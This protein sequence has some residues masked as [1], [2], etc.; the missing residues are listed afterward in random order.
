MR[1]VGQ[2]I[3]FRGLPGCAA[4]VLL[5]A[6]AAFA[7]TPAQTPPAQH[8][9]VIVTGTYDPIPLQ[10]SDRDVQVENLTPQ[11]ALLS[12]ALVDF[13][14][15]DSTIDLQERGPNGIQTDISIRGTNFGQTL[16]LLNGLRISDVQ[17]GHYSMDLPIPVSAVDRIEV[18]KGA[19]STMY[20]ADA[21]G[22]V[23]NV[24]TRTPET[25]DF[26]VRFGL[27]NFGTNQ[28]RADGTFVLGP[29]SQSV[30]F[31]RDFSTGFAYDRD[32]RDLQ[33]GSQTHLK[34][35]FG[36]TDVTLGYGDRPYGANQFY[37]PYNSLERTKVW[38]AGLHRTFGTEAQTEVDFA[39]RRHSDLFVLLRDNPDYFTNRHIDE[40]FQ[41]ALRRWE[42]LG[43]NTRLHYG[44]EMIHDSIDSNNL[45][46]HSRT[47]AAAFIALDVRAL[48]RFSFSVGARE[49][50]FATGPGSGQQV[51]SPSASAGYWLTTRLRLHGSLSNAFRLPSYTDL[52]YHDP[53]NLGNP[54][55]QP[56]KAW[57]YEGGADWDFTSHLR[58]TV[59]IFELRERDVIDYVLTPPSAIYV[60]T[61]F[62]KL[63]FTGAEVLLKYYGFA[64]SYT[65]L[66]GA[67]NATQAQILASRY[68]AYYPSNEAVVSWEGMFKKGI[69]LRTRIGV[70]QRF[71]SGPYAIWDFYT[72]YSRG[73][74]HP[75][76]QLTNITNTVYQEVAGVAMPKRSVLGGFEVRLK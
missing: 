39:Y 30:S 60:A 6:A 49:E 25:G 35:P 31:S 57:D 73:R 53:G 27:G 10:E 51:F 17:T 26:S 68:T 61:N 74:I 2:T 45:G 52:Y 48:N 62:D 21:V 20:G 76:F 28:E 23:I 8:E 72:A 70:M 11:R 29:W 24:V 56:E 33:F 64:I 75:F 63:N 41:A 47:R 3:V 58:A 36:I 18:L 71:N 4:A 42:K 54:N 19:G 9:T 66:H 22:G 32:Y 14:K 16:I 37:G 65:A 46:Q 44:A 7:Q 50:I 15:L 69:L 38:F 67:Y 5:C 1:I 34:D 59:N 13:L 43:L 12:N 55:L 40:T